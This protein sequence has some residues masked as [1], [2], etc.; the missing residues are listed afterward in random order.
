MIPS[1]AKLNGDL[2][3]LWGPSKEL[4]NGLF[5]DLSCFFNAIRVDFL[6]NRSL[7]GLF[8]AVS[9]IVF[10]R[11][12]KSRR[13]L[14]DTRQS[15]SVVSCGPPSLWMLKSPADV[16]CTAPQFGS[17]EP[18]KRLPDFAQAAI[19][20]AGHEAFEIAS[21]RHEMAGAHGLRG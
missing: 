4:L 13:P 12:L 18:L 14:S 19:S 3:S 9:I 20:H 5:N 10:R 8:P 2:E 6:L 21:Q 11:R 15:R 16:Q 17:C 1:V 7:S